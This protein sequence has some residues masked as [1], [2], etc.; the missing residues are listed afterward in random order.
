LSKSLLRLT[1]YGGISCSRSQVCLKPIGDS[2][3][4]H[5]LEKKRKKV[6]KQNIKYIK[7]VLAKIT[8]QFPIGGKKKRKFIKYSMLIM[9]KAVDV[10][11]V[12][13][14]LPQEPSS[15]EFPSMKELPQ[16]HSTE[17]KIHISS[18][19]VGK[20]NISLQL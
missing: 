2:C 10:G 6:E 1:K 7:D 19:V 11:T 4:D 9:I 15:M 17:M 5:P 16:P 20:R 13:K 12:Y 3:I 14:I 8:T 18:I